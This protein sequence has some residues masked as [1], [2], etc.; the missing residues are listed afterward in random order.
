MKSK[1][2]VAVMLLSL[3]S[4][5]D[6]MRLDSSRVILKFSPYLT[7]PFTKS[8]VSLGDVFSK[9]NIMVFTESGEKVFDKVKTQNSS[10][11]NFGTLSLSLE[12]GKYQ[13]VAVGHSSAKSATIKSPTHSQFTAADGEKLTDTFSYYG[14]IEVSGKQETHELMMTRVVAMFRLRLTDDSIPSEVIKMKFDYTGGSANYNAVTGQGI[15][16]S[17]QSENRNVSLNNIYEV[18]TFPYLSDSGELKITVSALDNA[19]NVIKKRVFEKVP[20]TVNMITEYKGQFFSGS[21]VIS[22]STYAFGVDPQWSGTD[23]YEF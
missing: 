8:D 3:L 20:I 21:E 17:T 10:D 1:L 15:T 7:T 12:Y 5:S 16:K 11:D 9:L 18:Y 14:T 13:I 4:C 22:G 2:F 6:F 23:S 19:G